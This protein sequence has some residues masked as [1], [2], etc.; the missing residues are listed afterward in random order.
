[1]RVHELSLFK[2]LAN[3]VV[4]AH[5]A[6]DQWFS[7]DNNAF[8][9]CR[10]GGRSAN[11]LPYCAVGGLIFFT[12]IRAEQTRDSGVQVQCR[13]SQDEAGP[14]QLYNTGS[15]GRQ[16]TFYILYHGVTS[17]SWARFLRWSVPS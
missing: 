12:L 14:C 15:D 10:R 6:V 13:H 2:D 1:M 16:P 9:E 17:P 7:I 3:R 11:G 5:T 4:A 8:E